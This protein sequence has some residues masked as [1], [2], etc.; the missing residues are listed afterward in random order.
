MRRIEYKE[1]GYNPYKAFY[2]DGS[3]Q[4]EGEC[5][6]KIMGFEYAPYPNWSDL[7]WAKCYRPDGSLGSEVVDGTGTQT[8]WMPDGTK[9]WELELVNH[10]RV[11]H[12]MWY[13]NGQLQ[14]HQEYRD[15]QVHGPYVGYYPSGVKKTEGAYDAGQRVGTWIRYNEDG[16]VKSTESN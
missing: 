3:L 9:V 7:D 6:I 4:Q 5:R 8:Q 1:E 11:A 16:S 13:P 12:T 14:Q 10:K 2:S 15:G